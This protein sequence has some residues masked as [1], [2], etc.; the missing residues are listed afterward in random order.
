MNFTAKKRFIVVND[1]DRLRHAV[2]RGRS[3]L[4]HAFCIPVKAFDPRMAAGIINRVAVYFAISA[5]VI[6]QHILAII[7]LETRLSAGKSEEEK[8][9]VKSS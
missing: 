5:C 1:T 6:H 9:D 4:R 8:L 3:E 7:P 2:C